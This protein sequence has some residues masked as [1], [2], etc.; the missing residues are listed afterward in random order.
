MHYGKK[1]VNI[2]DTHMTYPIFTTK[3]PDTFQFLTL[4]LSEKIQQLCS[5]M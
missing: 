1:E 4:K 2:G 3:M 5:Y